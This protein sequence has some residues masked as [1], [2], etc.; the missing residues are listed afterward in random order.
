MNTL[1][2]YEIY[3]ISLYKDQRNE[4][5]E[6]TPLLQPFFDQVKKKYIEEGKRRL[7]IKEMGE[8]AQEVLELAKGKLKMHS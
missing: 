6:S 1:K 7:H 2:E 4:Y 5:V 8:F 3:G